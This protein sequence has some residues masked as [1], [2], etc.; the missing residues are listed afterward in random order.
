M[1][2]I[3]Y[4]NFWKDPKNDSYL[5]KF[6]EHNIGSVIC[7]E[8]NMNP[9]ILIASCTGDINIVIKLKAKCKLFYYGENLNRYSP[10]NNEKLLINTFDL[11]IGFKYTN[12]E[13]KM[14]RFPLWLM[15]YNYYDYNSNSGDNLLTYIENKYNKNKNKNKN[16]FASLIARH[17]RE[18]QRTK[19][20]N[21]LS[22]Y[23]KIM[24]PGNF[25]NNIIKIGPTTED[26]IN[27]ISNSI[28]NIC[29]ENSM[30]EGYFTEKIFQAFEGGTIPLYWAIDYPEKDMINKNKYC[31]CNVNNDKEL[32]KSIHNVVSYPEQYLE[33]NIFTENACN[34]IKE[35][36]ET[37]RDNIKIKLGL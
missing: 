31:F 36:Y 19:I 1:I 33:G 3:S 35:Y 27:Y 24:Y 16:I 26:K 18:G 13:K 30:F 21:E 22:K 12:L 28:Y 14:I 8:P 37:L 17:D 34:I 10:Y 11:I 5:T 25:N 4:I 32:Q 20:C 2:T 23:G 29:P 7:I 6:I 15:Y 9:D